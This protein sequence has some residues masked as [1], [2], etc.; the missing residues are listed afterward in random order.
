M[1]FWNQEELE[2]IRSISFDELPSSNA[3]IICF[4]PPIKVRYEICV[5]P[6]TVFCYMTRIGEE[7]FNANRFSAQKE[8]YPSEL[9]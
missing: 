8:A 1:G 5:D 6:D 9:G 3:F 7:Q 4:F 2:K